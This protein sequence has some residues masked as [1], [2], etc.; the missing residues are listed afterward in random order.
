MSSKMT[1]LSNSQLNKDLINGSIKNPLMRS[2]LIHFN[3]LLIVTSAEL[4][5]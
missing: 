4:F 2:M 1:P 3:C 5:N